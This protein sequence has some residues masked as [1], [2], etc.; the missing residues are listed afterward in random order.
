MMR[1]NDVALLTGLLILFGISVWLSNSLNQEE[2]SAPLSLMPDH[3]MENLTTRHYRADG[4]LSSR[5]EADEMRYYSGEH[6]TEVVRPRLLWHEDNIPI[7][8]LQA[9]RGEISADGNVLYFLGE[10]YFRRQNADGT[11]QAEI[12]SRDVRLHNAEGTAETDAHTLIRTP[13]GSE[14][15][16]TGMFMENSTRRLEL[17]AEVESVYQGVLKFPAPGRP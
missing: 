9:E 13:S 3:V 15:R 6:N 14:L 2:S 11:L 17:R 12:F 7:W 1:V 8:L 5:L 16:G 10:A 4:K